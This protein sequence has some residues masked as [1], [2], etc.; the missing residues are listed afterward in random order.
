MITVAIVCCGA[1][2]FAAILW[3]TAKPALVLLLIAALSLA[4]KVLP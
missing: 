1:A 2:F 3:P 4:M